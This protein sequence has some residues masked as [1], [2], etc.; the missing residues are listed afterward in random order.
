MTKTAKKLLYQF[1]TRKELNFVDIEKFF[2]R[3]HFDYKGKRSLFFGKFENIILWQGWNDAAVS[4]INELLHSEIEIA[5]MSVNA[6]YL[7]Y[8]MDG[9]GLGFP[10]VNRIYH[11]K[12]PHWLPVFFKLKEGN[13]E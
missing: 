7:S 9:K 2:K 6:A 13:T 10:L 1:Q 11:Y 4:V 12:N 8:L 5:E 3:I